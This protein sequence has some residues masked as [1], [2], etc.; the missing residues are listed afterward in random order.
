M[1][2]GHRCWAEISLEQLAENFK[3]VC[4]V[5]TPAV[6]VMP[7]VKAN[8]CGHGAVEVSRVLTKHGARWL[9][10]TSAEEAV[11][12]RN[13]GITARI[14][15]MAG[16]LPWELLTAIE[17]DVTPVLH[18]LE[19]VA[20]WN[21]LNRDRGRTGTYHL[22]IDSGMWRLGTRAAA[23]EIAVAL[24]SCSHAVLEGLMTHFASAAD[25]GK[26]QTDEQ[27]SYFL[28][29]A[30]ELAAEGIRPRYRHLC[31]TVPIAYGRT[32]AW[33]GMVRPGHAIYGYIAPAS[34]PK[35]PD[36]TIK[37]K[38]ALTW[39]TCVL[40]VK[41]LPAG[42]RIGYRGLFETPA[43]MR[44]AILSAGY[45]DGIPH[46]L[47]NRGIV[48][49]GGK[50]ARIL[51]AIAMDLTA[52]DITQSPHLKPGDS[53]TLLGREGDVS[54]D[55]QTIGDMA[56]TSSYSVLCGISARVKRLYV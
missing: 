45:A 23:S 2:T 29:L 7:V 49:A 35:A 56:G 47:A 31:G 18:D 12:L 5:V 52:I 24:R 9:A 10:V 8:A 55:A 33:Q 51:G 32:N 28:H 30:D 36:Q 40:A 44:I 16:S 39:K 26:E 19:T 15:I 37:V 13:A 34:G 25:Y 46:Q 38:P 17:Y 22:K 6:E 21:Q 3:T 43:P 54:I 4:D 11:T 42:V 27:T 41:D 14:L 20:L 48:I 1:T 50:L 53:V